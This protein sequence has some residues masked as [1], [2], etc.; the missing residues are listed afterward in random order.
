MR[1]AEIMVLFPQPNGDNM[2]VHIDGTFPY[3]V[4]L[5]WVDSALRNGLRVLGIRCD[6]ETELYELWNIDAHG[7]FTKV[8]RQTDLGVTIET[9]ENEMP[10]NVSDVLSSGIQG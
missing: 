9:C 4:A 1:K 6:P 2:P 8:S 5:S 10:A 7:W 3:P